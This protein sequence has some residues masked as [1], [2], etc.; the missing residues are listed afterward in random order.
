MNRRK[1][2]Q[3][4]ALLST[5]ALMPQFLFGLNN[6]ILNTGYKRLI[7]IQLSGGN[8]G[9]NMVIPREQ[10]IYYKSRPTLAISMGD[11]LELNDQQSLH[12]NL[13]GLK[14]LYE[15]GE[16]TI[17]NNVG[18]PNPNRS[19][20]RSMDIWQSG[21]GS[22]Q[23][24]STGWLGRY[25]ESSNLASYQG[26]EI[27][28]ALSM[29]LKGA[30]RSGIA[31]SDPNKLKRQID[32]RLIQNWIDAGASTHLNEHNQGY[33]YKTLIETGQSAEIIQKNYSSS[34]GGA[35]YPNNAFAK[36]L[37]T[38]ATLIGSPIDT[39]V[40]YVGMTGFDTHVN[41][42]SKQAML[43]DQLDSGVSAFISDLKK[44][45]TYSDSLIMIF[46]EFGRRVSEN[47]SKGTDHGA[48][49]NVLLIGRQLKEPGFWNPPADLSNL[50]ANGDLIYKIDFRTIYASI[51]NN[52]LMVDSNVVLKGRFDDLGI[53]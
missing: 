30:I 44:S 25:L 31:T 37:K 8:D 35:T 40:Y 48:A 14:N 26:L 19:H 42:K 20:F 16:L 46:S 52:W 41:Q 33:L 53:V 13:S 9:L 27:N 18:Y 10:D 22:E 38:T 24:W 4:S 32:N 29:A 1:F 50:D 21:S 2:I 23:N 39:K 49:S 28:D 34:S 6:R 3:N 47:A 51:L 12:P 11:Q 15:N 7:V 5:T 17:I 45:G 36:Q 43:L